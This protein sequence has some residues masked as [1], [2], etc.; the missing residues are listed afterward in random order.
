MQWTPIHIHSLSSF[1]TPG[2]NRGSIVA[3]NYVNS[4]LIQV[5]NSGLIHRFKWLVNRCV[6]VTANIFKMIHGSIQIHLMASKSGEEA[7]L[8]SESTA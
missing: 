2:L 3:V 7:E 5:N 6:T 8:S 4:R 1:I